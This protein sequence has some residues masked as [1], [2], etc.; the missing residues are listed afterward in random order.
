MSMERGNI[1]MMVQKPENVTL[2]REEYIVIGSFRDYAIVKNETDDLFVL[3]DEE[4][5]LKEGDLCTGKLLI[6]LG[7][8]PETVRTAIYGFAG[9]EG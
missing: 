7:Q 1:M 5:I 9:R 2:L 8:L 3:P 4:K 6:P